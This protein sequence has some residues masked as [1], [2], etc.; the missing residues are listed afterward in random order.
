MQYIDRVA[1]DLE[2]N[3]MAQERIAGEIAA[4]EQQLAALQHDHTVLVHM[5]QALGVAHTV[6]K[7]VSAASAG[8]FSPRDSALAG[9]RRRAK[10]ATAAQ[11]RVNGQSVDKG[12]V[13][14]QPTLVDLVRR[15]LSEQND[16]RSARE[17]ATT[18]DQNHS[19]REIKTTVVRTTL[20]NL[21]ARDLARRTKQG[22]SVFYSAPHSPQP[23]VT[24]RPEPHADA[25][26]DATA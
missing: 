4:L 23:T 17:I 20:E 7:P 15:H 6:P 11:P 14:V 24:P 9:R 5:Q 16:A 13:T 22:A 25:K 19:D 10:E 12:A 3:L 1:S 2:R 26:G 21:V 8:L 18:L